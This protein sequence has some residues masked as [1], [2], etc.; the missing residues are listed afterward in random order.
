[1]NSD[2]NNLGFRKHYVRILFSEAEDV[3]LPIPEKLTIVMGKPKTSAVVHI[4]CR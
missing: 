1:M 4:V 2:F 3:S